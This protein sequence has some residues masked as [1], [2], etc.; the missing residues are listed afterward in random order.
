MCGAA[1]MTIQKLESGEMTCLKGNVERVYD[2]AVGGEE[3][4]VGLRRAVELWR[5]VDGDVGV[6]DGRWRLP[7]G[8]RWVK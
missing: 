7:K 8:W 3:E 2:E 5:M 1:E 6:E 4:P